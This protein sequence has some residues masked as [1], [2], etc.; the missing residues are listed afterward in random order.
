MTTPS[1]PP[2]GQPQV[3]SQVQVRVLGHV[4]V[5]VDNHVV[6]LSPALLSVVG[7]LALGRGR[8]VSVSRM[9]DGLWEGEA[10]PGTGAKTLLGHIARLRRLLG[11]DSIVRDE[12]GYRFDLA[13]V[14]IDVVTFESRAK[15]AELA[16]AA[17]DNATV[18]RMASMVR[19]MWKGAPLQGAGIEFALDECAA[20][21]ETRARVEELRVIAMIEQRRSSEI[22]ADLE[23]LVAEDPN[24]ELWWV[25][26][27]ATLQATGRSVDALRAFSRLRRF[28]AESDGLEPG[29]TMQRAEGSVLRNEAI[30][31]LAGA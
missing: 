30:V 29:I 3:E 19:S 6:H 1:D 31:V 18:V 23:T 8:P 26:L 10:I 5:L 25:Y 20:L 24:R 2:P 16:F 4:E 13:V 27:M 9:L 22:V 12:F 7:L 21:F 14:D 28:L 15:S 11:D 17:L